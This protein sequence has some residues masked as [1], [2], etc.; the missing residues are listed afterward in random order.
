MGRWV[1]LLL[2]CCTLCSSILSRDSTEMSAT[3]VPNVWQQ[4]SMERLFASFDAA[5]VGQQTSLCRKAKPTPITS[6]PSGWLPMS[7]LLPLEIYTNTTSNANTTSNTNTTSNANTIVGSEFGASFA[8]TQDFAMVGAPSFS[9]AER[10]FVGAVFIYRRAQLLWTHHQTLIAPPMIDGDTGQCFGCGVALSAPLAAVGAPISPNGGVVHVY[11]L[12]G[13]EWRPFVVVRPANRAQSYLF[14]VTVRLAGRFLYVQGA[15]LAP[16]GRMVAGDAKD[17]VVDKE[18]LKCESGLACGSNRVAEPRDDGCNT[19]SGCR[20]RLDDIVG[21]SAGDSGDGDLSAAK[22][23]DEWDLEVKDGDDGIQN[24]QQGTRKSAD[25]TP[26]SATFMTVFVINTTTATWR[27][28][29]RMRTRLVDGQQSLSYFITGSVEGSVGYALIYAHPLTL[30]PHGW[31]VEGFIRP[32]NGSSGDLFG[33]SAS[34][35]GSTIIVGAPRASVGSTPSCGVAH[36]FVKEVNTWEAILRISPPEPFTDARFGHSVSID[37]HFVAISAPEHPNIHGIDS[38]A[39]FV[40]TLNDSRATLH[41]SLSIVGSYGQERFGESVFVAEGR[42]LFVGAPDTFSSGAIKAGSVFVYTLTNTMWILT[43]VLVDSSPEHYAGFGIRISYGDGLLYVCA[44]Q[45]PIVITFQEVNGNWTMNPIP[46][47]F[48]PEVLFR[49][50]T[51]LN[52]VVPNINADL[53]KGQVGVETRFVSFPVSNFQTQSPSVG[54]IVQTASPSNSW[55]QSPS[56]EA[57]VETTVELLT[58]TQD[59]SPIFTKSENIHSPTITPHET[60]AVE[61]TLLS[62]RPNSNSN[63]KSSKELESVTVNQVH[64]QAESKSVPLPATNRPSEVGPLPTTKT[65]TPF[66]FRSEQATSNTQPTLTIRDPQTTLAKSPHAQTRGSRSPT[67]PNSQTL[68]LIQSKSKSYKKSNQIG[69][70][71]RS[72][73]KSKS[74]GA[75][76]SLLISTRA[77]SRSNTKTRRLIVNTATKTRSNAPS[78]SPSLSEDTR[79]QLTPKPPGLNCSQ[80]QVAANI[81]GI[82]GHPIPVNARQSYDHQIS[83]SPSKCPYSIQWIIRGPSVLIT[84]QISQINISPFTFKPGA[85]YTVIFQ[86]YVGNQLFVTSRILHTLILPVRVSLSIGSEVEIPKNRRFIIRALNTQDPNF[87]PDSAERRAFEWIIRR[88]GMEDIRRDGTMMVNQNSSPQLQIFDN[89]ETQ[90]DIGAYMITFTLRDDTRV[91]S[92]VEARLIVSDAPI[93]GI[94][95]NSAIPQM[96][97]ATL[98]LFITAEAI[99]DDIPR[100]KWM[101]FLTGPR[102]SIQIN[103]IETRAANLSVT[104][105]SSLLE[106]GESYRLNISATADSPPALATISFNTY[107]LPAGGTSNLVVIQEFPLHRIQVST[108]DW[109]IDPF[110]R[111]EVYSFYYRLS[112]SKDEVL[113]TR[114][115]YETV[116]SITL[117]Y[118]FQNNEL[119]REVN[120]TIKVQDRLGNVNRVTTVFSAQRAENITQEQVV[121]GVA[122]S[123]KNAVPALVAM[124]DWSGVLGLTGAIIDTI[125]QSNQ[126]V[127]LQFREKEANIRLD[128]VN[129]LISVENSTVLEDKQTLTLLLGQ[130]EKLLQGSSNNTDLGDAGIQ[131]VTNI[132]SQINERNTDPAVGTIVIRAIENTMD[133]QSAQTPTNRT[134]VAAKVIIESMAIVAEASA[135]ANSCGEI[136]FASG[137]YFEMS[138][139]RPCPEEKSLLEIKSISKTNVSIPSTGYNWHEC[140]LMV[141][142]TKVDFINVMD[143]KAR[144]TN[145]IQVEALNRTKALTNIYALV[146][147]ITIRTPFKVS[148]SEFDRLTCKFYN[149]TLDAWRSD[150]CRSSIEQDQLVC[151]CNHM[152]VFAG[153]GEDEEE[154]DTPDSLNDENS[155][156]SGGPEN[157]IIGIGVAIPVFMVA[158]VIYIVRIRRQQPR[159]KSITV[160]SRPNSAKSG[161]S[162]NEVAV[163]DQ[164]KEADSGRINAKQVIDVFEQG[165]DPSQVN[166]REAG[167]LKTEATCEATD[168]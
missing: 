90:L 54:N 20:L 25:V 12:H 28:S 109:I 117:P 144:V 52:R 33:Y 121:E 81:I 62:L 78:P 129:A 156:S 18:G 127:G 27:Q 167:Q 147:E 134:I 106:P 29:N 168:S 94:Q 11:S 110:L 26:D 74:N 2:I 22:L 159:L 80:V 107:P 16:A 115:T 55:S 50:R 59:K 32:V 56:H 53:G 119:N 113:A 65:R 155:R 133:S 164:P 153:Y 86:V 64:S 45:S 13:S 91:V 100:L 135:V 122:E 42:L 47:V 126:T 93:P 46:T 148:L 66:R 162:W 166:I 149:T 41:S 1:G 141:I 98:P 103:T 6:A 124:R 139:V 72:F 23:Q 7:L 128:I 102:G 67:R 108:A 76:K 105:D 4:R 73:E 71:S 138:S 125:T 31:S 57:E 111:P 60:D 8:I 10:P 39:V 160:D 84:E 123:A 48:D 3:D 49:Q 61:N 150:G 87:P 131:L 89:A 116:V 114:P 9:T 44:R 77:Q 35:S 99:T 112:G 95:L 14:G 118:L 40:Y 165:I 36:L 63:S 140:V 30:S 97:A 79:L 157:M 151:H 146:E 145:L 21:D 142:E 143:S 152:T 37:G 163:G 75:S 82:A 38:G 132:V 17:G 137:K 70:F 96:V 19:D 88:N 101:V 5:D 69:T 85:N 34:I 120:I 136:G 15:R 104:I 24:G 83:I 154:Q 68:A 58:N 158:V 92:S 161:I 51:S 43:T 130:S